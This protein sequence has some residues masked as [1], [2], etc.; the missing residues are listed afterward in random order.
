MKLQ[1]I[2]QGGKTLYKC[3]CCDKTYDMPLCFGIDVPAQYYS[4]PEEE[5]YERIQIDTSWCVMD[6]EHF[7]HRGRLT[8]PIVDNDEDL[9]FDI[10]T[11]ISEDNFCKR[12]DLWELPERVNEL[13]YFGWLNSFIPSYGNTINLKIIAIEQAPG[14]IP[15]IKVTEE[16]H[17][18]SI[19]Q[20]QGITMEKAMEIV[21][22]IL[23]PK[24]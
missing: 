2:K 4:I 19:D 15:E 17:P 6:E 16:D 9:L 8:I 24:Q 1:P 13:P 22:K 18:L 20:L 7:F 3:E 12:M 21:Y 14:Y 5:R 11:S 10:W 23:H